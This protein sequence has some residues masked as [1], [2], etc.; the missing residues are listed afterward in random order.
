MYPRGTVPIVLALLS[1]WA[2]P[3][4]THAD[5]VDL[6]YSP[7]A[8][9]VPLNSLG[10]EFEVDLV[11]LAS[12]AAQPFVVVDAIVNWDPAV[13]ELLGVDDSNACCAWFFSGF[14]TDPDAINADLTDGQVLYTALVDAGSPATAPVAPGAVITTLRFRALAVTAATTISFSPAV[15][16]F[17]ETRV[18]FLP[19]QDETGSITA[20]ATITVIDPEFKRG[21]VNGD[22]AFNIA[23]PVFVLDYL[24]NSGLTPQCLDAADTNDDG[25]VNVA[26]TIAS[27][28]YLFQGGAPPPVPFAACGVDPTF[29]VFGCNVFA[30][31]P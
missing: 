24:F 14:L 9:T 4:A 16:A 15:G 27:L 28:A 3:A 19:G 2:F 6:L 7:A 5:P 20:T 11:A 30:G 1:C 21:D 22:L 8:Q 17:G 12:S 13:I 25:A 29:D 26:D 18:L 23:D 10:H 31:C